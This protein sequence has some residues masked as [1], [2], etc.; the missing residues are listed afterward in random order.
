[1][2]LLSDY[3]DSI[4]HPRIFVFGDPILD[5]YT[6]GNAD[7][8]SPEAPVVVLKADTHEA[9]LGGAASVAGLLSTLGAEVVLAGVVGDDINGRVLRRLLSDAGIDHR[10]VLCDPNRPT[11]TKERFIGRA[12]GRHP[13]QILRVDDEVRTPL[14]VELQSELLDRILERLPEFQAVLIS[15][16]DKGV[17]REAEGQGP[18]A[19]WGRHPACRPP[20][21]EAAEGQGL[22]AQEKDCNS[23]VERISN[24]SAQPSTCQSVARRSA[25]WFRDTNSRQV[26]SG[27]DGLEIRPTHSHDAERRATLL[28]I[29]LR[30][31]ED[32]GIPVIV[33][34]ARLTDYSGY[35]GALVLKPNRIEAELASGIRIV[36]PDDAIRAGDL[37]CERLGLQAAVITLDCDGM[38]LCQPGQPGKLFPTQ[39]REVY[40]ITGAGDMGLAMLGLALANPA[41][42]VY[43][44]PGTPLPVDV[45]AA[46]PDAVRLANVA[47]GLEVQRW[48][49]APISRDEIRA[50][51]LAQSGAGGKIV[52][53]LD[54]LAALSER[55]SRDGKTI[56]VT[57][58]C[59]DL[60]H[61]GHVSLLEEAAR[62]GDIL[63]VAI[64]SDASTRKLKGDERPIIG[65]E[66]R[67][68]MLAALASV[69][70][71][72]IFD[73]DTPHRLLEAIRPD[74]L[75]KGGTTGDIVGREIVEAYGGR[76]VQT[77]GIPGFSTTQ[78]V[79]RLL[80]PS[81]F[82]EATS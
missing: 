13:H 9:R 68:R 70:H 81:P 58:G 4:G 30:A 25:S 40:D 77:N 35:D 38:V 29:V 53:G 27:S 12:A 18:G 44:K 55:Y 41:S 16:Y 82:A 61:V 19:T 63:I 51:L 74:V 15:D 64:N 22:W 65:E 60:L 57:N 21:N 79:Q 66:D 73:D 78:L 43:P 39:T 28:H 23:S 80:T 6:S 1:M 31:A 37:L 50:E 20:Q 54:E 10:L 34:P 62:L 14:D 49:V 69:D 11:T 52:V 48:G 33:D 47:A 71:V 2:S 72:L 3:L 36:T 26:E 32:R 5:R 8:V 75:V 24:P 67:A 46:L 7:R 76:I 56:V 59:F 17:C 42:H 45:T